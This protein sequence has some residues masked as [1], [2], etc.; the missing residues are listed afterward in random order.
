NAVR[1]LASV[2]DQVRQRPESL[3]ALARA[4]YQTHRPQQAR[5]T[6]RELER[7]SAGS[8]GVFLGGEVAAQAND[9]EDAGRICASIWSSYADTARLVYHLALVQIAVDRS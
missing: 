8:E 2:P 1:L 7:S 3:A 6:L 9:F 4:Y 5:E